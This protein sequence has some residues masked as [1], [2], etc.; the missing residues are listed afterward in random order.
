MYRFWIEN[1][2]AYA[3]GGHDIMPEFGKEYLAHYK[4]TGGETGK[5]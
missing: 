1:E 2:L 5:A 3:M 4:E